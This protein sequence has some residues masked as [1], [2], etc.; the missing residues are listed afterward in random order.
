[1]PGVT[2]KEI[3]TTKG[4]TADVTPKEIGCSDGNT[5]EG[6]AAE[7]DANQKQID[8]TQVIIA[9]A[10]V[11]PKEIETTKGN[12]ADVT[13][14]EIAAEDDVTLKNAERVDVVTSKDCD[15][16]KNKTAEEVHSEAADFTS[17]EIDSNTGNT[18]Q[19]AKVT[20][21]EK[22][23]RTKILTAAAT[24]AGVSV[25]QNISLPSVAA[26]WQ[27]HAQENRELLDSDMDIWI[28]TL[29]AT[30]FECLRK[31]CC[32]HPKNKDY[33]A[34]AAQLAERGWVF[35]SEKTYPE[36]DFKDFI[37]WLIDEKDVKTTEDNEKLKEDLL[38]NCQRKSVK[39]ACPGGGWD[40][41]CYDMT[42]RYD[43]L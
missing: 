41:L 36:E 26:F 16:N 12:T 23:F 6:A 24:A 18:T 30:V 9:D 21:A 35:M 7:E 29:P 39:E 33:V 3:E 13:P 8:Q 28:S 43:M 14:K 17:K 31:Q 11:T 15:N 32:E 42:I 4:N 34:E 19:S 20:N 1:M 38:G 2:Q 37:V 22:V 5:S 25:D 40:M 27:V 10:G